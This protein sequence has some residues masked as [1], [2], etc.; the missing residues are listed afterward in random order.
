M[1]GVPYV[2]VASVALVASVPVLRATPPPAGSLLLEWGQD[3][4]MTVESSTA[5][6]Q[7]QEPLQPVG[8]TLA[9]RTEPNVLVLDFLDVTCGGESLLSAYYHPAGDFVFRKH[10]IDR[11]PWD[12]AV[13]FKDDL[14][15]RTFAPDSGFTA[16]YR[17]TIVGG[18]PGE[19]RAVVERPDLYAIILCT[20][21]A[22][23]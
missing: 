19:L 2:V 20:L 5:A 12:A 16:T 13:Q 14:I 3:A 21:I 6:P 23:K 22:G 18:V 8:A 15:R 17:F 7:A 9:R 10:G 4:V 1:N 11:N